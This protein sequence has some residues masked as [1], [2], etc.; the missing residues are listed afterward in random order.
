RCRDVLSLPQ[1][2]GSLGEHEQPAQRHL[3]RRPLVDGCS[4]AVAGR[5]AMSMASPGRGGYRCLGLLVCLG[6]A[7]IARVSGAQERLDRLT[8][9]DAVN[10]AIRHNATLRAKG[11]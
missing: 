7:L 5:E 9:E 6:I 1:G 2:R 10:T 11:A 4:A 3:S 8:L